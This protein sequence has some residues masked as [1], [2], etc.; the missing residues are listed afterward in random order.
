M[1]LVRTVD[2]LG[3]EAIHPVKS[4]LSEYFLKTR[5]AK[6]ICLGDLARRIGY[7]NVGKGASR[8]DRFEKWGG[9]HEI[10]LVKLAAA[11]GIN[12]ETVARLIEEDRQ[13]YVTAWRDWAESPIEPFLVVANI[14]G[15]CLREALPPTVIS[16]REAEAYASGVAKERKHRICLVLS[17]R[18]SVWFGPDGNRTSVLEAKPGDIIVPYLRLAKDRRK[19]NFDLATG[20]MRMLNDPE[21]PGVK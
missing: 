1:S 6:D 21:G 3:N 7:K 20:K 8:I 19:F 13:R 11:L 10:L 9:I 17:R 15:F 18:L 12:D 5:L 2:D 16:R 4:S 14:G